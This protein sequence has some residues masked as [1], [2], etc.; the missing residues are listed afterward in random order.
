MLGVCRETVNRHLREYNT[1]ISDRE[2][3]TAPISDKGLNSEAQ[4][5][6]PSGHAPLGNGDEC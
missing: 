3:V 4:D 2:G 6:R 5:Q 1:P